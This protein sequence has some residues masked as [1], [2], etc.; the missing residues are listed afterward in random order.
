MF[1]SSKQSAIHLKKDSLRMI[2]ENLECSQNVATRIFTCNYNLS[3]KF[4]LFLLLKKYICRSACDLFIGK[5]ILIIINWGEGGG[6]HNKTPLS[7]LFDPNQRGFKNLQRPPSTPPPPPH[8]HTPHLPHFSFS[9]HP[10]KK[11]SSHSQKLCTAW[12]E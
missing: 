10:L 3:Y 12:S 4:L 6:C 7:L 9:C 5:I 2:R 8:T 11:S 1:C